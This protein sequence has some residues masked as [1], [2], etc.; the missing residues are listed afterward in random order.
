VTSARLVVLLSLLFVLTRTGHAH[1]APSSLDGM[2]E[3][4]SHVE[5]GREVLA[6]D[7]KADPSILVVRNKE[8]LDFFIVRRESAIYQHRMNFVLNESVSP[9]QVDIVLTA[10][11]ANGAKPIRTSVL[12]GIY[13]IVGTELTLCVSETG[14]RRP[15]KFEGTNGCSLLKYKQSAAKKPE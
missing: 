6:A 15:T 1:D 9:A 7:A 4:I 3:L 5:N 11:E 14:Q 2:W 8:V 13:S 10:V 12:K